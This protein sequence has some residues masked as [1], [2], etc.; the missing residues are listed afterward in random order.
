[1]RSREKAMRKLKNAFLGLK[2]EDFR[3]FEIETSV[4]SDNTLVP[5]KAYYALVSRHD[6]RKLNG[7][8]FE[9]FKFREGKTTVAQIV[10]FFF[11]PKKK[12]K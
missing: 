8:D 3:P 1:M 11:P 10:A 9:K 4:I 12:K 2:K 7:K 6:V 5:E